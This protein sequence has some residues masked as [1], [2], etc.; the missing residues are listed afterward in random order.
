V[1]SAGEALP[2]LPRLVPSGKEVAPTAGEVVPS[3]GEV[4]PL[5]PR[6]IPSG[7]EDVSNNGEAVSLRGEM[8]PTLPRAVPSEGED[9][10]SK[11]D[12]APSVISSYPW[13]SGRSRSRT[14]LTGAKVASGVSTKTA[15]QPAIEPFQRPGRSS[16][17]KGRPSC[18]FSA[19]KTVDGST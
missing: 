1:P 13:C 9:L 11:G 19:K 4:S 15:F 3:S 6:L 17:F 12:A 18:D 16:A 8:L 14:D 5:L 2:T 7:G 10:P